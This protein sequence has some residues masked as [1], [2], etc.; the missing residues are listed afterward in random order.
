MKPLIYKK[1][2]YLILI[3]ILSMAC[4][5][6]ASPTPRPTLPVSASPVVNLPTVSPT[7]EPVVEAT[8]FSTPSNDLITSTPSTDMNPATKPPANNSGNNTECSTIN[9]SAEEQAVCGTHDYSLTRDVLFAAEGI[10]CSAD[11]TSGNPHVTTT[12]TISIKFSD[13]GDA[14][15]FQNLAGGPLVTYG[16]VDKNVFQFQSKDRSVS[17]IMT[18]NETGFEINIKAINNITGEVACELR[19]VNTFR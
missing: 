15:S 17:Q 8:Q 11:M 10:S 1:V 6:I 2:L 13:S 4:R 14:F 18:I 7:A 12:A 16:R 3:C 5:L 9:L 19:E